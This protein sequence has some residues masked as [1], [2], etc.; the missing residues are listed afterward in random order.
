MVL[1]VLTQ[2]NRP[3][4]LSCSLFPKKGLLKY[5][6]YFNSPCNIIA[7]IPTFAQTHQGRH[8]GLPLRTVFNRSIFLLPMHNI[9][10]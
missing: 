2:E 3:S 9:V 7:P 5:F 4:V 10:Q 8:R 1:P 6:E